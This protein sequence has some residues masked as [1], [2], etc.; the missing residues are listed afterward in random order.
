MV[1][2]KVVYY[3]KRY[4]PKSEQNIRS[5]KPATRK[6]PK[7]IKRNPQNTQGNLPDL[8][9]S[10]K[11]PTFKPKPLVPMSKQPLPIL[12]S[13]KSLKRPTNQELNLPTQNEFNEGNKPQDPNAVKQEP[14]LVSLDQLPENS[15]G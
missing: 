11:E 1:D 5:Q 12:N 8:N 14:K 7:K 13:N 2:G 3:R 9:V 4:I 10:P 15:T 6:P